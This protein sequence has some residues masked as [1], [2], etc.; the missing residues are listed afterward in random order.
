ML[1]LSTQPQIFHML[2]LKGAIKLE[3]KGLKTRG[4]S[5]YAHAKRIYGVKGS[6]EK[7]VTY[8]EEMV[9]LQT[10]R[11]QYIQMWQHL[12]AKDSTPAIEEEIEDRENTIANIN[13]D[14]NKLQEKY[15]SKK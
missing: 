13:A 12:A 10:Q 7:I 9:Q 2:Q 1:E 4:G 8:L 6:R 14:I 5:A 11:M 3:I 15:G